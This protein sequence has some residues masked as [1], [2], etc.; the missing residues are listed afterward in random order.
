MIKKQMVPKVGVNDDELKIFQLSFSKQ[1][2]SSTYN[3]DF[4]I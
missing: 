2:Y 4:G 1:K 3:Y